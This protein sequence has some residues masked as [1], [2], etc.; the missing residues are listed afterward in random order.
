MAKFKFSN[1]LM[2]AIVMQDEGLCKEFIERLFPDRKVADIKFPEDARVTVEKTI[3]PRLLSRS[4]RLDVLFEGGD[5]YYDIEMQVA[6][7]PFLPKRS[8]YYH[9]TMDTQILKHGEPYNKLKPGYVIF[10]CLHDPFGMGEPVY[11]FE[12]FDNN[13]QLKLGDESYTIILDV[14][15]SQD[16]IPKGLETFF[17]YVESES[18]AE[19]DEFIKEI[20]QKVE[21]VN[22]DAEVIEIMTIEE[23]MRMKSLMVEDL[24][25]ELKKSQRA[26]QLMLDDAR[27]E[28]QALQAKAQEVQAEVEKAQAEISA[29]KEQASVA[30]DEGRAEGIEQGRAEEKQS[31]AEKMRACGMS[32]DQIAEIIG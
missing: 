29:L 25:E 4:V 2:F 24:K 8:R 7:E 30:H 21:E 9:S 28:S 26:Q 17:A 6:N 11:S 1:K 5:K 19:N 18:V 14:K 3:I 15:G 12:M 10:I 31:I 13:L 32:D 22:L 20:H 23:D 27:A 16:K